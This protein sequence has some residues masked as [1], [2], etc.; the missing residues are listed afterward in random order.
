MKL[1]VFA[2]TRRGCD[3]AR[4]AKEA[5]DWDECRMFTMAKFGQPD[6]EPYQPPLTAFTQPIFQWAD[7]IVFVGST[8][9]AVRAIAPWVQDK[10]T[11]PGVIVVDEAGHFAIS[12]LSGHIGGANLETRILAQRLGAQSVITT[13]TDINGKFS[14]DDWAA[15]NGLVIGS[16]S[17]AK[18]VAAAI[19]EGDVP[20]LC[21]FPIIGEL[22]SGVVLGN[23]GKVGIY[24][25]YRRVH[26]F[27]VTLQLIPKVLQL[28]LGCRRGTSEAAIEAAVQTVLGNA[29]I[30][31][32]AV[33]S[34][35]SIDL[36]ANEEGLL[37]FCAHHALPVQFYSA[38]T[39]AAVPGDFPASGFVA[40]VTGVDNVCQRSAM[41]G[42][43]KCI[44]EKTA[45]DGV[46]VAV[47]Q[48]K[49]EAVF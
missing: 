13:A 30:P 10:K 19:L 16:M 47:A 3:T 39:L 12:L 32:D 34:A 23:S 28:G 1:A 49:W 20:L 25:G 48:K 43:E 26:P 22:P 15:R 40:S 8:G 14:V 7:L 24:I 27:D 11:D 37:S 2:F 44:I 35:A 46:T 18:A 5:L 4:R 17:A 29:G 31:M 41:L 33:V 38:Q 36:K 9:M 45:M 21:D 42:A 6:F